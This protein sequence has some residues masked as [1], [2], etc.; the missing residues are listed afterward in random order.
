MHKV[1]VK[2]NR[3][4]QN[5][6]ITL[7][8]QTCGLNYSGE[9]DLLVQVQHGNVIVKSEYVE[10]GV[11]YRLLDF[12]DDGRGSVHVQPVVDAHVHFDFAGVESAKRQKTGKLRYFLIPR[13]SEISHE[14]DFILL[15]FKSRDFISSN[16]VSA[17]QFYLIFWV[18]KSTR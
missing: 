15:K 8:G 4:R 9:L 11:H 12:A 3:R 14:K 13:F 6:A 1:G 2:V 16:C 5:N 10:F 18:N 7:C 17:N